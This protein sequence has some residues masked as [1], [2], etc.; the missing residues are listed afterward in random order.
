VSSLSL[1]QARREE[2]AIDAMIDVYIAERLSKVELAAPISPQAKVKLRGILKKYAKS[3]HPFRACVRDNLK[4]FGPGR[5]EAICATIKDTIRGH[6][7]WR[8]N[9]SLDKGS[10]GLSDV[11]VDGDVLLALDAISEVDLMSIFMGARAIEESRT[12]EALALSVSGADELRRWGDGI[13][14]KES[15]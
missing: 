10:A 8:G 7:R 13:A 12:V 5:T 2:E 3:P 15:D 4:R 1:A 9:K 14:L 6:K 11:E